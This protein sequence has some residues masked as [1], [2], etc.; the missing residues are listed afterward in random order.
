MKLFRLFG[1]ILLFTFIS[2]ELQA[3]KYDVKI[4]LEKGAKYSYEV[5]TISEQYYDGDI[6]LDDTTK[7]Q[8]HVEVVE[9][10]ENGFTLIYIEEPNEIAKKMK[11]TSLK[12]VITTDL[13]GKILSIQNKNEIY[14]KMF[15]DFVE[16]IKMIAEMTEG[17]VKEKA[18][19]SID[20]ISKLLYTKDRFLTKVQNSF[21]L[22]NHAIYNGSDVDKPLTL[23]ANYTLPLAGQI[24]T[25]QN[26]MI[27]KLSDKRRSGKDLYRINVAEKASSE[28]YI[29]AIQKYEKE[30][31]KETLASN[32][33]QVS[34][35]INKEFLIDADTGIATYMSIENV[36]IKTDETGIE[37]VNR[38]IEIHRLV[39]EE[40]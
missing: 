30:I 23:D 32:I 31:G 10:D 38:K 15:N 6:F 25:S 1:L 33:K 3:E 16:P 12:V 17:E 5:M 37:T 21:D 4:N 20:S 9:K 24:P 22:T 2:L 19:N 14:E 27:T 29:E 34:L 36:T 28:T 7:T 13:Y 39:R 40:K 35:T 8:H 18:L 26:V 11:V